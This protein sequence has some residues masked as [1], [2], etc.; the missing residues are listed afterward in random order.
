MASRL[1]SYFGIQCFVS[2]NVD[3][4]A[5]MDEKVALGAEKVVRQILSKKFSS[6]KEKTGSEDGIR[7]VGGSGR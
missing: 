6:V 2:F 4:E 5:E 7:I 3:A 1:A